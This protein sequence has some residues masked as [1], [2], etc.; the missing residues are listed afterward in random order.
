MKYFLLF[1]LITL[2]V[3]AAFSQKPV[4]DFEVI[5]DYKCGYVTTEFINQSVNADTFLWDENDTGHF[6]EIY[7]PRGTNFSSDK[8]WTATLIAI[9]NGLRDTTSKQVVVSQTR[10]DFDYAFIDSNQYAP[11]DV[12]FINQSQV[13]DEDTL[14]YSWDFGNDYSSGQTNPVFTY[15]KP[16]T[17]YITLNGT[18]NNNCDLSFS[19]YLIVKDTAQKG[20]VEL[21]I[22]GCYDDYQPTPCGDDINYKITNDSIIFKGYY[23]GNCGTYKTA[24]IRESNDSVFFKIWEVGPRTTCSCGNCFDVS[25]PFKKDSAI[26][27][28]NDEVLATNIPLI[29]NNVSDIKVYP[30][31]TEDFLNI[32]LNQIFSGNYSYSILDMEGKKLQTGELTKKK[33]KINQ[34]KITHGLYILFLY[35]NSKIILREKIMVD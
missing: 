33:I 29:D 19:D 10:L 5:V 8:E 12:Q 34:S 22:S 13:R 7:E 18:K 35:K 21:N 16:G 28:Y 32:E 6:T 2:E 25:F 27:I 23:H 17:Y 4:A 3:I 20:E 14:V 15:N 30:N 9:G 26:V 24:T 11:T 31:P 1:L